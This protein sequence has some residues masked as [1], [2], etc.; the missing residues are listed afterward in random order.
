MM[1]VRENLKAFL[2]GQLPP[3][4]A[5]Q[6][7][8]SLSRDAA[9]QREF[10]E[11]RRISSTLREGVV[12]APVAGMDKTLTAL[13]ARPV[14]SQRRLMRFLPAA[15]VAAACVGVFL[16]LGRGASESNGFSD[17]SPKPM[18]KR[19]PVAATASPAAKN[20]QPSFVSPKGVEDPTL[21]QTQDSVVPGG[22][23]AK[24]RYARTG[25]LGNKAGESRTPTTPLQSPEIVKTGELKL[26]V[27]SAKEAVERATTIT[28]SSGGFVES[29]NVSGEDKTGVNASLTLRVPVTSFESVMG[30]LRA[31]GRIANESTSGN[32][33][34]AQIV[35]TDARLK[36]MRTEEQ[37]YVD[38]L[39]KAKHVDDVLSVRDRL[40]EVRQEI[41]SMAAQSKM[42]KDQAAMST[43]N[44]TFIQKGQGGIKGPTISS[45]SGDWLGGTWNLAWKGLAAA[46]RKFTEAM[47]YLIVFCPVWIPF[48]LLANYVGRRTRL[49]A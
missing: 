17:E 9:L 21:T 19:A 12:A 13:A 41:E 14:S 42:L 48:A 16:I 7:Q 49:I 40:D 25:F 39:A 29:S 26:V 28:K 37:A 35:D 24:G 38:I 27:P 10:D 46:G 3:E 6:V 8:E 23:L 36:V 33:V 30:Q 43:I 22:G 4:Q 11:M 1:D 32:D 31:M 2:D 47:I 34:T 20:N 44:L 45:V 15:A 18:S 5:R